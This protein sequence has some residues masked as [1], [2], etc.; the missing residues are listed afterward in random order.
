MNQ[1]A[2]LASVDAKVFETVAPHAALLDL[3]KEEAGWRAGKRVRPKL[4]LACA[5][6]LDFPPES[7]AAW[8]ALIEMIHLASLV[9]DDVI[10]GAELRR[11]EASLR[12]R[13]GNRRAVLAGDL[14]VA[15]AW[16]AA[17]KVLPPAATG[18]LARA[19]LEMTA[20]ELRE[21]ELIW[22]PEATLATYLRV[23]HGKTA[24]LF[25]AAAEGTALLAGAP[26][27]TQRAL[28]RYGRAFG[29]A[30][31]IQD[32]LLDYQ[33]QGGNSGKDS[34][35][36]LRE[37]LA[38]LP[39][40]VALRGD[41]PRARE[42]RGYLAAEGRRELE[43]D[44]ALLLLAESR[45]IERSARIARRILRGGVRGLAGLEGAGSLRQVEETALRS[46]DRGAALWAPAGPVRRSGR[47]AG[48]RPGT[49]PSLMRQTPTSPAS[50]RSWDRP[51]GSSPWTRW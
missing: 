11:G 6:A 1:A 10:D 7:A 2:F 20:A 3:S 34:M 30:F 16:L 48:H 8:A 43:P 36:D 14:V 26:T 41:G 12:A 49:V 42:V 32:D 4:V 28:A 44:A 33:R 17:A 21:R 35:K 9:H 39:L 31:Q 37:G 5:E 45:A 47:E 29:C 25:A 24:A 23:I 46:N 40:I 15:A 27:G 38:T 50:R 51:P 18:L 19:M 13:D 22:N